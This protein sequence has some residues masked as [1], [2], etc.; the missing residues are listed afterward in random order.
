MECRGALDYTN[1]STS[2][3][4]LTVKSANTTVGCDIA[5]KPDVCTN[6]CYT[7]MANLLNV[8]AI[9]TNWLLDS[10]SIHDTIFEAISTI[11]GVPKRDINLR[12]VGYGIKDVKVYNNRAVVVTFDDDTSTKSV[13]DKDDTFSV[14]VGITVCLMKKA[15]GGQDVGTRLYNKLIRDGVKTL[16]AGVKREE[17]EKAKLEQKKQK[18]RKAALKRA[19]KA[20]R[21]KEEAIDI[22]KQGYLRALRE[23]ELRAAGKD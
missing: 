6:G 22:Q 7:G 12:C 17:A 11:N 10:A 8:P 4:A 23:Q 18:R 19:A 5:V 9:P 13:C 1:I 15:L 2:E 16:A 21:R 20:L 3:N 14:E